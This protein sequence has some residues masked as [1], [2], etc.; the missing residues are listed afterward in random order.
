MG[1]PK[2]RKLP[3]YQVIRVVQ[4]NKTEAY[5]HMLIRVN[6]P[7]HVQETEYCYAVGPDRIYLPKKKRGDKFFVQYTTL[8]QAIL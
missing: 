6:N 2:S 5:G 1:A 4:Q 7:E 3:N 8:N